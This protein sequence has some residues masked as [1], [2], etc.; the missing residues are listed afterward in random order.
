MPMAVAALVIAGACGG[1]AIV[2]TRLKGWP[3]PV[4]LPAVME[5]VNVPAREGVPEM[6]PVAGESVSPLGSPA[7]LKDVGVLL[8]RM[9]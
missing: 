2:I 8:A 5:T 1:E 7:A 6:T 4:A 3:M 9:V